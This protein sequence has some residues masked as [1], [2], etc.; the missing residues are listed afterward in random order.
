MRTRAAE[1]LRHSSLPNVQSA[2]PQPTAS[3]ASLP[4]DAAPP[5]TRTRAAL[6]RG[7]RAQLVEACIASVPLSCAQLF[8]DAAVFQ[9]CPDLDDECDLQACSTVDAARA[10]LASVDIMHASVSALSFSVEVNK[11][12]ADIVQ[13]Q[14]DTGLQEYRVPAN[15]RQRE[16][17]PD[18][19]AWREAGIRQVVMVDSTVWF[20]SLSHDLLLSLSYQVFCSVVKAA[21]HH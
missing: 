2:A 1:S 6:A 16:S 10:R 7:A 9:F 12:T 11:A 4:L 20:R 17:A 3:T 21:N 13:V 18:A 8:Y 19:L 15:H 14:T 5:S